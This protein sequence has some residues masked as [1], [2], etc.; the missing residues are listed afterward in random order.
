[1]KRQLW[2]TLLIGILVLTARCADDDPKEGSRVHEGDRIPAFTVSMSDGS[3]VSDS[4]FAGRGGLILFFNTG[5]AD[6]RMELPAVQQA[7]E[8]FYGN[9]AEI[10]DDC[11]KPL[12]LCVARGQTD[13]DIA[14]YWQMENISLPYSPQA[15]NHIYTLF[16]D[17][18]IPR[19]YIIDAD[20]RVCRIY[21]DKSRPTAEKLVADLTAHPKK[22]N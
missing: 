11:G 19:I 2:H 18:G 20:L 5:C 21:D 4:N 3:T 7:Y 17:S 13:P 16:A 14:A 22:N 1:M 8:A 12:F 9:D 15:D 6:C 10:D